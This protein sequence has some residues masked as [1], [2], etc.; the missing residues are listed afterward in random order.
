M[1]T[2]HPRLN[3]V[4]EPEILMGIKKLAKNY[5]VS[6]SLMA[7]DLLKEAIERYEDGY[8]QRVTEKREK[9]FSY[10]N[11]LTHKQIWA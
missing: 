9:N 5:G 10:K 6:L 3:V 11:A 4:L 7:R 1:A 8:W 2:K